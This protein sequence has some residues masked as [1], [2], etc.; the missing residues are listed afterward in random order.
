MQPQWCRVLVILST[1]LVTVTANNTLQGGGMR[2][3][4][5]LIP[6]HYTLRLLPHVL[7]ESENAIIDGFVQIDVRCTKDTRQI[8]LNADDVRVNLESIKV[9]DRASRERFSVENITQDVDNQF[10][11]LHL[12]RKTLIKGANYVIAMNFIS[13]LNSQEK[14]RGFYRLKYTEAGQPR[15]IRF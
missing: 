5:N 7:D 10:V 1:V 3:S 2:L 6:R 14:S 11:I 15:Y 4:R 13:Q 8:V 12:R 9:Y